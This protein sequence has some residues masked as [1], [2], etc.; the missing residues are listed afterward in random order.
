MVLE[1]AF[2]FCTATFVAWEFLDLVKNMGVFV[3]IFAAIM[4][5]LIAALYDLLLLQDVVIPK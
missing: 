3:I 2:V 5:V 4:A 1:N